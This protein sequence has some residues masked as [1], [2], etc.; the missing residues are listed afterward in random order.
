MKYDIIIV[1]G[2]PAGLSFAGHHYVILWAYF[3]G[4]IAIV[5]GTAVGIGGAFWCWLYRRQGNLIGCWVSH[6]LADAAIFTIGYQLIF[7]D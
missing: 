3:P 6:V 1:G 5:F 4:A 7:N 2:G